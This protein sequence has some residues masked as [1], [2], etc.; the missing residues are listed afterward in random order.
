MKRIALVLA[1]IG[2]MACARGTPD[3]PDGPIEEAGEEV[4]EAADEAE[5]AGDRAV[6]EVDEELDSD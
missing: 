5:A 1:V 3:E 4:D 6:D 2:A